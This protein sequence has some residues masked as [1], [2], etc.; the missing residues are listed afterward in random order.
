VTRLYPLFI[1][2]WDD[3]AKTAQDDDPSS[4]I[5]YGRFGTTVGDAVESVSK[6]S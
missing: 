6:N 5:A 3:V 1:R 2:S 4:E